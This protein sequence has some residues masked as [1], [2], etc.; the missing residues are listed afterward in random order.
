[1]EERQAKI[2][3]IGSYL[4]EK[5]L[6]NQDLEK[7][8]DTSDE[9]IVSRTGMRER[10]L[11]APGEFT[12]DMGIKAAQKALQHA[13]IDPSDLDFILVATL[14]PD[15]LFPSTACLIQK[16]IG[17][18]KAA[19]LDIQAAC[20]GF[21]YALSL[22]KGLVESGIYRN[23]L[24]VASER[25]SSLTDYQDRSTCIL[26]GDGAGACVVGTKRKP[27][28]LSIR[29]VC[30][31]A[32]GEQAELLLM[33]AGGCRQPASAE[34]IEKRLHYIKMSGNEVFKHAVRRME[35]ACK[36]CLEAVGLKE[37]EISW[38]IPHQA[39][40]R[41]IDAIAR[42]FEHLPP[43]RVFKTIEKYGNTSA[44]SVV[45]A[46]DELCK[47]HKLNSGEKILLTAFGSGLT[48]GAAVLEEI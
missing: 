14:S 27:G 6:T 36:E 33:P 42:R 7:M 21:L 32:D 15:Y 9:W 3:G 37:E 1:M 45:I 2:L 16:E 4:P 47:A 31:G 10:R 22:A 24:I 19:A 5:V 23:I 30:L 25:L 29:S 44:S 43:E 28:A 12:S 35:A 39:N 20:S 48:W 40:L 8:V 18:K 34:S 11:A 17:A 26:F 41:I 46:L 38:V 13:E